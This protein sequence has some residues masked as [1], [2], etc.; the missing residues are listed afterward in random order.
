M[1]TRISIRRAARNFSSML[2][3]VREL[4]ETFIVEQ[5]G[6]AVCRIVPVSPAKRTLVD[7]VR[8]LDSAPKPDPEYWNIVEAITRNQP[9]LFSLPRG[10]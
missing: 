1:E 2:D 8:I 6:E 4:G 3:R 7:L 10:R 5:D 9:K